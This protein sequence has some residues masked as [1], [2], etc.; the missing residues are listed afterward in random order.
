MLRSNGKSVNKTNA[1]S[2]A[3]LST[4][5]LTGAA[6]CNFVGPTLSTVS[7]AAGFSWRVNVPATM[8]AANRGRLT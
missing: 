5:L 3:N 7:T 1:D 2:Q 8:V 4:A 6:I